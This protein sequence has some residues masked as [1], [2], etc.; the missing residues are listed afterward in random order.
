MNKIFAVCILQVT[1][2]WL[3][4]SLHIWHLQCTQKLL[5]HAPL[6]QVCD[7]V[8]APVQTEPPPE[9]AGLV[10]VRLFICVPSPQVSLHC[11]QIPYE[12]HPPLTEKES[13][14]KT[15]II[16]CWLRSPHVCF[17]ASATI[18]ITSMMRVLMNS[19]PSDNLTF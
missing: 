6:L 2:D 7:S 3:E 9:G 4:L 1:L 17:L 10:H 16:L 5:G 11:S 19:E 8:V 13:D 12:D 18:I 15:K 14:K